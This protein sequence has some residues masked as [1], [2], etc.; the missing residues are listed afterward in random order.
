MRGCLIFLGII[1]LIA[2][3]GGVS[4][5]TLAKLGNWAPVA[6]LGAMLLGILFWVSLAKGARWAKIIAGI[7]LLLLGIGVSGF[8]IFDFISSLIKGESILKTSAISGFNYGQS[9]F[10]IL[11]T[12][13]AL[14]TGGLLLLGWKKLE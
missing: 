8:I 1:L 14:F 2:I 12:G 9:A 5:L 6:G 3:F 4:Q 7:L 11:A 13:V 10:I